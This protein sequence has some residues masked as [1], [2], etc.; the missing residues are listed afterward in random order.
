MPISRGSRLRLALPAPRSSAAVAP[1][2]LATAAAAAAAVQ[3]TG[4]T[5]GT[6]GVPSPLHVSAGSTTATTTAAGTTFLSDRGFVGGSSYQATSSTAIAGTV[7]DPLYRKYRSGMS[8]Y[9]FAVPTAASYRV[10]LHL[11]EL[12]SGGSG[13][14]VF[15]VAAEG[16]TVVSS[17]DIY[18][19]YGRYTAAV[20]S[21]TVPVND[22]MV[23]LSF[24]SR[25]TLP[26]AVAAIS[27]VP[28]SPAI[29]PTPAPIP[30]AS[31]TAPAP[32]VDS[33]TLSPSPA[34]PASQFPTVSSTGPR[35]SLS[36][37]TP[38]AGV[39]SSYDGQ[40]IEGKN[41]T[42]NVRIQHDNVVLRDSRVNF[43]ATHGLTVVK[44]AN[45]SCPVGTRFEYVDVDGRLAAEDAIPV[46]SP[47]CGWTLDHAYVHNVGRTSR[48]TNDNTVSN[49]YV[50]SNRTGGSGAHRGAVGTNGGRN[51]RIINNVLLCEGT[52]C[53][54]A[55]P[56]YGDF[57][58]VDGMLVQHNLLATTGSYC[59][60]GGS[61]SAKPY[62][63]GS[64]VR[65]LDNHFSTRFS[66]RCGRYGH[67]S[68]FADGVRGNEW[69]GN[70][71][72]ETGESA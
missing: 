64:K 70:V 44:K 20:R 30:A 62:P 21:F 52:G 25:S 9:R 48:L 7:D 63:N 50:H 61:L 68:G 19:Q 32:L 36:S 5:A 47:G 67:I 6:A 33:P 31:S 2:A 4:V 58:P 37:L 49:S 18:K 16:R 42:G 17:L 60:Y 15:D 57:A 12:Q 35:L 66:T 65:F 24:R 69:R 8:A 29:S 10:D 51:N 14:R 54:A 53:S 72:H 46:Y 1:L 11:V 34:L 40:V 56:M 59:A 3:L 28:S 23:D 43:T 71:W 26:P 41:I 55:I 13:K 39:T 38:S 45:G 27:I 22:G